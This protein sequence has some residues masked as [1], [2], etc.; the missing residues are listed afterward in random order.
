MELQ[1]NGDATGSVVLKVALG[2]IDGSERRWN[3]DMMYIDHEGLL[4]L[5]FLSWNPFLV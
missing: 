1:M 2:V 4:P 5:A 3:P